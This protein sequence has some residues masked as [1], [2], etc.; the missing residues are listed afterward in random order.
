MIK[1]SL[2]RIYT[3]KFEPV[4]TFPILEKKKER[5]KSFAAVS[6]IFE[7]VCKLGIFYS[8]IVFNVQEDFSC[9]IVPLPNHL[10]IIKFKFAN[11]KSF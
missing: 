7:I 8:S 11:D 2:L 4:F 3:K 10:Q 1:L 9:R 5:K 6:N